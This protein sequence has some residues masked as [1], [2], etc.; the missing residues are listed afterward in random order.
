MRKCPFHSCQARIDGST[1]CCQEHWRG[2]SQ[3]MKNKAYTAYRC[4]M[5]KEITHQQL[6]VEQNRIAQICADDDEETAR[7]LLKIKACPGCK[8]LVILATVAKMPVMIEREA[9]E[10]TGTYVIVGGEAFGGEEAKKLHEE[11]PGLTK[12]QAHD[13]PNKAKLAEVS[14]A[15]DAR[16]RKTGVPSPR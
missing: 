10:Y 8:R 3:E 15:N 4:Y 9:C 6:V 13:C 12:L 16:R 14:H 11:S 5:N 1:F 2:M 7:G